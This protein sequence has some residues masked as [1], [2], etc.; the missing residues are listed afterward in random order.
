MQSTYLNPIELLG[1]TGPEPPERPTLRKAYKRFL[2]ELE[3]DG[4]AEFDFYASTFTRHDLDGAVEACKAEEWLV[5]YHYATRVHLLSEFLAT[6]KFAVGITTGDINNV[7][8]TPLLK[9]YF[10]PAFDAALVASLKS[11]TYVDAVELLG[12]VDEA[13][14]PLADRHLFGRTHDV[15]NNRVDKYLD[16]MRTSV[17]AESILFGEGRKIKTFLQVYES[18]FPAAVTCRLPHYFSGLFNRLAREVFDLNLELY[19]KHNKYSLVHDLCENLLA[20]PYLNPFMR[21][22]LMRISNQAADATWSRSRNYEGPKEGYS[23][24]TIA[25]IAFFVVFILSRIAAC[26]G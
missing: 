21:S 26:A 24:W 20:L 6:G 5:A 16:L 15:L 12:L 17:K 22:E 2:T 4:K 13:Q 25:R 8:F 1:L 19:N 3:L 9:P 11:G 10:A 18:N 7:R 14:L 23:W